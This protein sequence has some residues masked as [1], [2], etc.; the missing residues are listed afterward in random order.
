L[1][2]IQKIHV[3]SLAY[4]KLAGDDNGS[5]NDE[6]TLATEVPPTQKGMKIYPVHFILQFMLDNG[7]F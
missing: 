5:D 7:L 4:I 6:M 3:G 1:P 2:L